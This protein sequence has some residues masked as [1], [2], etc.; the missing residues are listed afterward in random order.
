MEPIT[1]ID[2]EYATLWYHP[3][4][5]IVHHKIRQSLPKGV[6]RNLLTA[7][8]DHLEKHHARKWLS[9]DGDSIVIPT[10][11][12]EWAETVWAPRVLKAGFEYWAFVTSS[13]KV[14]A[15]QMKAFVSFYRKRGV[16]VQLFESVD[17]AMTWLGSV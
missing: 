1:I 3:D 4:S 11:D 7:G 5:G 16:K 17:E 2:D 14:A 6:F 15:L 9:D 12:A 8:A 10:E 13:K